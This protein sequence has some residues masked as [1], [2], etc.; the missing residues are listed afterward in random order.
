MK[1]GFNVFGSRSS[2]EGVSTQA[3]SG[4][5]GSGDVISLA[6]RFAPDL[7]V[8]D[9]NG[10][11]TFN[12][13]GDDVDNPFSVATQRIDETS[14]DNYRANFY[15][16]YEIIEGLSFKTTFGFVT[17]NQTRGTYVPSTLVTSAGDQG[18]IAG[19]ASGKRTNFLNENYLTYVKEFSNSKLTLVA[20]TSYQKN[21]NE[22]YSAGAQGFTSDSFSYFNIGA[23]T[24]QL[25]PSSSLSETLIVSQ[26]G[27]LNYDYADKYLLTLTGRRDGASNFAANEK[28]AFFPSGALGWKVSNEEFLKDSNT[29]SNL[30]LRGS[31]GVTGNPS[32]APY[33]SLA[34]FQNIY[35]AVG[36]Q[37]VN[38]VVPF[39]SA[40]PN[41]KWE[42]SYQTNYGIDI[43]LLSNKISLTLDYYTIDTKD[44]ILGDTSQPEYFGFQNPGSLKNIGEINNTGF[45]ITLNTR[46]IANDN[47]SWTTDFNW[48]TNTTK[49]EKLIDGEDVLLDASPGHFIQD[50]THI[51]REGEA[52]GVF[53]GYEYQGVYQ[54][55]ALPAG[56]GTLTQGTDVA[57]GDELFTDVDGDGMITANEDKKI[58]GD[59]NQDWTAGIT[60]TFTYKDFDLSIFFQGAYG[61]D[62][63]SFTNIELANG[64]SNA[65][66]EVLNA[67][68]P[69]NT[70]TN[71]PSARL[72][73]KDITSRFVYDGSY[74][75]LKNIALGY[76]LPS[77]VT[78]KLGMDKVRFSISGQNLL[79]FTDYPG[80]D[81]EVSYR[82]AGNQNSN[83]NQGF[84]YGNYPNI[85]SITFS[86][87]LKF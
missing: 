68:T 83:V 36:G 38:A 15:G 75:R 50:V 48:A 52:V 58:I 34:S 4:G 78:D 25:I 7:G 31:Y 79:T 63:M 70:N 11:V 85:K 41:L 46:N 80:T 61:G 47:F 54:G 30:K 33:Q 40:N 39:Q 56:T 62:I 23:G 3:A 76:N 44:V 77:S 87:N 72:R 53:W 59:P 12:S 37:T 65:T 71:V 35:T 21:K 18:G 5:R 32:I 27:R 64:D 19:I 13:V 45:E 2:K 20:G 22:N 1:L 17:V 49:I 82:A 24:T 73:S 60:N 29:I 43:G 67:W 69:T 66:T 6:G 84:D 42:S 26:F 28:Y 74:I 16:D 8:T 10:I 86:A 51:L 57:P 81:P 14:T 9:E 55:G